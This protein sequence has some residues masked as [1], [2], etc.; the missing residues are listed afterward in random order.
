MRAKIYQELNQRYGY[1]IG[2]GFI[3]KGTEIENQ[4]P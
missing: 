1:R 3:E 2:K 4:C